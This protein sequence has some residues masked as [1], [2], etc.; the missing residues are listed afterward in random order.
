MVIAIIGMLIALLLPAV[1]AAREAARRMQCANN[2]KQIGIAIHNFH[3]TYDGVVP[4]TIGS[5]DDKHARVSFFVL[6]YPFTEQT[7]LYQVFAS[8]TWGGSNGITANVGSFNGA[9]PTWW[10][11]AKAEYPDFPNMIASVGIYRCPT[12][13]SA[14]LSYF[15]EAAV[16]DLPGPLGDYAAPILCIGSE[17]WQ[18][19]YRP[20]L[21][22][23]YFNFRGP[24]R[25][26]V[27]NGT[28]TGAKSFTLRDSFA[29]WTD[30]T[31]NQ[32]VLGEKHIPVNRLGMSK[33]GTVVSV[34][35][36]IGDCTYIVGARWGLAGCARNILS[37][38]PKLASSGDTEYEA[39][40]IQPINGPTGGSDTWR[41]SKTNAL[42]GGYDFG[43]SHPGIC[44]FL[45]GDGA[46]RSISNTVPKRN[47]L[48]LLVR[49]DDNEAITLP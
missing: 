44:Q 29:S 37:Q 26:A 30:G 47:I 35:D 25:V 19:C 18:N 34:R 17:Y 28:S 5:N 15:D 39:N 23:D 49:V 43:S 13:R 46:V 24:L 10:A 12:R 41:T 11:N 3:N 42:N 14:N 45:I 4:L 27:H 33:N 32:L 7:N 6:L 8:N 2:L 48:A 40:G 21:T 16:E 22:S 20:S 36:N 1:Q 9:T 38:S 31:S